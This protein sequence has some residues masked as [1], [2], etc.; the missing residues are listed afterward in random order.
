MT[1][2]TTISRITY[3]G[4]GGTVHF[5]VPFAF[6]GAE[7]IG[8]IERDL[9]SGTEVIRSIITDYTVAGGAGQAGTIT[10]VHPLAATKSWTI[11]R[12]THRTQM[13]DYTPNDPFPAETHER[14]LDRL[15]ALVQELDDKLDRS[16]TLSPTSTITSLTLPPP[17]AG[18]LIGWRGDLTGLENKSL[19]GGAAVFAGV[20]STLA[21]VVDDEVV[22][23][24]A[25]ASLWRKGEDIASA[26]TLAAPFAAV[27]G[28]Y[29][30]VTGNADIEAL[31]EG[32]PAGASIELRFAA[33]PVLRHHPTDF[34]LPNAA[35]VEVLPG[36]VAR[37]RS[38]G[39]GKWR[40][41]SAPPH[42][43]GAQSTAL[44]SMPVTTLT[45]NHAMIADNLGGEV[46]FTTAGVTLSLLPA[47]IAG[48]GGILGVRHAAASGE[49][50][51][52]PDGSET[53]D[54]LAL[55]KL[56]PGD[57]VLIRSDGVSWQTISGD[58]SYESSEQT[59]TTAG[60]LTLAHG[61]G[62]KP[63]VTEIWLRCVSADNGYAAG[64]EV[65]VAPQNYLGL[66]IHASH[67]LRLDGPNIVIRIGNR[68]TS[69]FA[70][71]NGGSGSEGAMNNASWR[72]IARARAR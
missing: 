27:H 5:A 10:A 38:E 17:E 32:A 15:T 22:T 57:C 8:V 33:D 14:A 60:L 61:L 12:R 36:D 68:A 63:Y 18:R 2:S 9:A 56:R 54:G 48:N 44:F 69:S 30:T 25:L 21:G 40:C 67:S 29:H 20:T 11:F 49:V 58:Y 47:A 72:L 7:E 45:T 28:G 43:Y 70:Y 65:L 1:I 13:V 59:I 4:D 46:Q 19:L 52:D 37:F 3:A 66:S 34:V 55:R 62:R 50:T 41:V 39:D 51:I 24:F 16:A 23:P 42:W 64:Q 31:W 26:A 71:T 35:D 53:L 6:F